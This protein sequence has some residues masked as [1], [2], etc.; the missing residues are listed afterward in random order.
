MLLYPH[1]PAQ[2]LPKGPLYKLDITLM[3]MVI[4]AALT[5]T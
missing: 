4:T 1:K 3:H 2:G 5:S